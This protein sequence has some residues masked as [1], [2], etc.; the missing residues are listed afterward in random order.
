MQG[1]GCRNIVPSLARGTVW[2]VERVAA[3]QTGEGCSANEPP[4]PR[5][6][7]PPLSR[8][9][10]RGHEVLGSALYTLHSALHLVGLLAL[11]HTRVDKISLAAPVAVTVEQGGSMT[12]S[13]SL[14]A[15]QRWES[16]G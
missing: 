13:K 3:K 1:A 4:S 16:W 15:S 6:C 2:V 7:A 10:G 11:P 5:R 14:Y 9:D 8:C 12:C